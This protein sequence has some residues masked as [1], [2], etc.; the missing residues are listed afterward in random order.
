MRKKLDRITLVIVDCL[1]IGEAIASL[2]KSLVQIEPVRTIFF[3]DSEFKID[4]PEV[5]IIKIPKI[6]SKGLYSHFI[7]K[8][9]WKYI[10]TDFVLVSQW[11]AWV[12]NGNSW[13]DEFYEYDFCA[14]PWL[15]QDSRN[16]GN[17]GFSLRSRKLQTILGKDGFIEVCHP[18]DE[19]IGRLYRHY[20]EARHK[21][22]FASD[23][24]GDRFAF[25]LRTPVYDTF[26]FHSF[27]HPP[28]K[29]TIMLTRKGA[30]GDVLD[31]EPLMHYYHKKGY[32]I[33]LNTQQNW[34]GFFAN[35][36][37]KVHFPQEVDGRLE[38]KEVNLDM[39]YEVN[40]KQL[41]LKSYFQMAGIPE[42]EWEIRNTKLQLEYDHK[43]FKLFKKY[44]VLHLDKRNEASR[45]IEGVDWETVTTYLNENGYDVLQIGIGVH[46]EVKNATFMNT[47]SESLLMA[48]VG[49]AD[50]FIG[51]DSAPSHIAVAMN[52]KSI[53]LTGSVDLRYI[54]PDMSNVIWMH[55]HDKK[56]C[57]Q[58][59]C[60]HESSGCTGT[61]CYISDEKPPCNVFSTSELLTNIKAAI[62]GI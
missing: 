29:P 21:I 32:R 61:K 10:E 56:V 52:T 57:E 44:V 1:K 16:M 36:Y 55:N 50:L 19:I 38:Y 3:T 27:F 54:I 43:S 23:D 60:W 41:H 11:D 45:N 7:V 30:L 12:L 51:I 46:D 22:K 6:T 47:P 26:G 8:E 48:I 17:G 39:A 59:F 25:E 37:F 4:L 20:L 58:A 24:V 28:Y 62:N 53:I 34:L 13:S 18:E 31:M 9:L 5:E 15:Y 49:S 40:P 42:D 14:S 2:Q 33:V 35:H